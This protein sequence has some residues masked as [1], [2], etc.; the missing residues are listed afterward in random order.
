MPPGD[1]GL[2]R[3]SINCLLLHSEVKG[4]FIYG[5]LLFKQSPFFETLQRFHPPCLLPTV[6]LL[7][8][9]SAPDSELKAFTLCLCLFVVSHPP[10]WRDVLWIA[11]SGGVSSNCF[12]DLWT[13]VTA[14]LLCYT[15]SH[16]NSVS[17]DSSSYLTPL[18]FVLLYYW[19]L[20]SYQ[21]HCR[22]KQCDYSGWIVNRHSISAV[23][24]PA[25]GSTFPSTFGACNFHLFFAMMFYLIIASWFCSKL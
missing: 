7:L 17:D 10:I 15:N 9:C 6:R 24:A 8:C 2:V 22:T 23:V 19:L 1:G 11:S 16:N 21:K 13:A 12:C 5:P 4:T 3:S 25:V 14:Q 18:L 20:R